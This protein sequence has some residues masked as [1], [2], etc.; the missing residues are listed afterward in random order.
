M[1]AT[2]TSLRA[3][4]RDTLL[5]QVDLTPDDPTAERVQSDQVHLVGTATAEDVEAAVL[6]LLGRYDTARERAVELQ[7]LVG[8]VYTRKAE[9]E[10]KD[11]EVKG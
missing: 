2:I 9:A 7:R 1:K 11:V 10:V 6:A 3:I 8:T 4:D 5:V